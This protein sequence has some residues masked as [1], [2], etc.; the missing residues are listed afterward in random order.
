M[1]QLLYPFSLTIDVPFRDLDALGHVNNAVYLSYVETARVKYLMEL[2]EITQLTDL[3][4]ILAEITCTYH[5]PAF[6]NEQL[7]VQVGVS[8]LGTKS[9]DMLF[10]ITAQDG[11]KV[12]SGRSVQVAYDYIKQTSVPLSD[13]FRDRVR[14]RQGDWQPV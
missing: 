5:S 2:M 7:V 6:F 10:L 8:R 13:L 12:A 3:T 14:A 11:R 9:F 4:V 1:Q